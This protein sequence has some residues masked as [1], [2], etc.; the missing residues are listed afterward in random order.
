MLRGRC[1]IVA[2]RRGRSGGSWLDGTS[3]ID[4]AVI[5]RCCLWALIVGL[6]E[7]ECTLPNKS[8]SGSKFAVRLRLMWRASYDPRKFFPSV[9]Q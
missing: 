1:G 8:L 6:M 5:F 7:L 2:W 4:W 3:W 9:F